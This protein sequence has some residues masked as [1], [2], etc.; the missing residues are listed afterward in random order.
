MQ[1]IFV[2]GS[3]I[4]GLGKGIIC[5]N[6]GKL[7]IMNNKTVRYLKCDP[8]LNIDPG[9]MSPNEHGEVFITWDG[10]EADMDLGHFERMTGQLTGK[11]SNITS[12]QIYLLM[13]NKERNGDFLGK[14]IRV[15][16]D[17]PILIKDEFKRFKNQCDVCIIEIGGTIGDEENIP[18]LKAISL[19][20]D[21]FEMNNYEDQLTV[22]HLGFM[23]KVPEIGNYKTRLISR[24]NDYLSRYNIYPDY[25]GL[26][27]DDI[28][29]DHEHVHLVNIDKDYVSKK[30]NISIDQIMFNGNCNI[31]NIYK[32][33]PPKFFKDYNLNIYDNDDD[34]WNFNKYLNIVIIGKYDDPD[35]YISLITR[36]FKRCN[37]KKY[38]GQIHYININ[39]YSFDELEDEILPYNDGIIIAGGFGTSGIDKLKKLA[40]YAYTTKYPILGICL[41]MQIMVIS[42]LN[43]SHH[44]TYHDVYYD[45]A[46]FVDNNN[47]VKIIFNKIQE[48]LDPITK[49]V[50]V[51]PK[52]MGSS[53]RLGDMPTKILSEHAMSIYKQDIVNER[54]RHR[55]ELIYDDEIVQLLKE[56]N[57]NVSSI[58]EP[59]NTIDGIDL[60]TDDQYFVGV[61]YH[62]E[63]SLNKNNILD[64]FIEFIYRRKY[65]L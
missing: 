46:E 21:E 10:Y 61:Q 56:A 50:S 38:N 26:R 55:Y 16:D 18:F 24:A 36:V 9:L 44:D 39:D 22:F 41:G 32:Y 6:I 63:F 11:E 43:Q 2:L 14:T 1:Y 49:E 27:Y 29:H 8:Y 7:F 34:N 23:P 47:Q 30:L 31:E 59:L 40:S 51:V 42:A 60:V 5:S 33:L 4:S 20:D 13:L 48:R 45:S 3:G 17:I 25:I 35:S 65:E 54:H 62:P 12:G 57:I 37:K 58:C 52:S 64:G 19:L 15:P 28:I 53:M